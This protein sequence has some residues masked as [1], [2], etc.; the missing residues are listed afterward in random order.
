[1]PIAQQEQSKYGF[2]GVLAR[3]AKAIIEE[4]NDPKE[5]GPPLSNPQIDVTSYNDQS[6]RSAEPEGVHK[7][8]NA[9]PHRVDKTL[10]EGSVIKSGKTLQIKTKG[11][12]SDG[13][14]LPIQPTQ[15]QLKASRDVAMATAA[16]AK[17]LLR[18][19]KTV[20]ADLAFAKQRSAQLEEEN[21]R[22]RESREKGGSPA[23]DDL[24]RLQIETLLAEKARLAH[25]NSVYAR[26][27]RFLREIVE[28]HHLTMHDLVYLDEVG[29]DMDEEEE[30]QEQVIDQDEVAKVFCVAKMSPPPSPSE[31]YKTPRI[32]KQLINDPSSLSQHSCCSSSSDQ[33]KTDYTRSEAL[34]DTKLITFHYKILWT[35]EI[36]L[37]HFIKPLDR[38]ECRA[39]C[40]LITGDGDGPDLRSAG[41]TIVLQ[42]G[43]VL[44]LSNLTKMGRTVQVKYVMATQRRS[45]LN[46]EPNA[47]IGQKPVPVVP[48]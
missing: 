23:D 24:I 13:P 29:D 35:K 9:K 45:M 25:E 39:T 47:Y 20:K 38:I 7:V 1:S 10:E 36:F 18:E 46:P 17:L 32:V 30:Q 33:N 37:V 21:R 28:Y 11:S 14:W 19:L 2:W 22:F 48:Q 44:S 4:E 26:E 41:F 6:G 12:E 3:K 34:L 43:H 8:Y 42:S 15:T 16:K 40:E 5:L 27:N 31:I